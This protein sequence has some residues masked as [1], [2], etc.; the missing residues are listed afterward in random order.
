LP[1]K[2]KASDERREKTQGRRETDVPVFQ[3]I[4]G[5]K[6]SEQEIKFAEFCAEKFN[7]ENWLKKNKIT[8][9]GNQ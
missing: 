3:K 4:D 1:S 2:N 6:L 8:S 9:K 5:Q 7:E